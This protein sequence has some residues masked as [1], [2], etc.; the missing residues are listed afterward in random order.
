VDRG[1]SRG[2]GDL[3]HQQAGRDRTRQIKRKNFKSRKQF[4]AYIKH[5]HFTL[6]D[7]RYRV[8]LQLLATRI[9]ERAARGA[10]TKK[11]LREK[12]SAF[13]D[14]YEKRWRSRTVCAPR[15]AFERC[16]ND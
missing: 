10:R 13:V 6:R 8:E 12:L 14:A 9:E 4:Y 7:I 11:E 5:T 16:S 3:R 15:Y 2:N 1:T